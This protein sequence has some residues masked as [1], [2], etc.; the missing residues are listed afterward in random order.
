MHQFILPLHYHC[1]DHV[2][3]DDKTANSFSKAKCHTLP[4]KSAIILGLLPLL[5]G[6]QLILYLYTNIS[7][8][9]IYLSY[10]IFIFI[11]ISVV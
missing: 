11:V 9:Y 10:V 4:A 1:V 7:H 3:A 5:P 2:Q 6:Q 8:L